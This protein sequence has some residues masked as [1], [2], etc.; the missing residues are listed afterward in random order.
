[1]SKVRTL[2]EKNEQR[3]EVTTGKDS[4][5]VISFWEKRDGGWQRQMQFRG[6]TGRCGIGKRREGDGRTPAGKL[7]FVGAFGLYPNPGTLFPYRRIDAS[8]YLVDDSDSVY[9]NQIVSLRDVTPDWRSSEHM[10][11]MGRAYRYGLVTDYNRARRP[12]LGSGIFLHC[13]EGHPT[14]GCISVPED[15]MLFLLRNM[16]TNCY[17][18]IDF[19]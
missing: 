1:M 8:H 7:T 6:W 2:Q 11:E 14:A 13:E 5:A 4:R 3:I 18:T 19:R 12:G 10:A 9:Y 16:S 15:R 17:M